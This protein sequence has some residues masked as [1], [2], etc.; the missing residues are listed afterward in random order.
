MMS[1]EIIRRDFVSLNKTYLQLVRLL[2]TD[3]RTTLLTGIPIA[4]VERIGQMSLDELDALAKDLHM[5]CFRFDPTKFEV[6]VASDKTNRS[7]LA[8]NTHG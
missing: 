2:A 8:A 5:P 3:K 7:A 1:D 4:V 6:L